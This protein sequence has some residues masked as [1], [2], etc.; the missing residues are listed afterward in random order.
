MRSGTGE[1]AGRDE[2]GSD[3][4]DAE[5]VKGSRG[6]MRWKKGATLGGSSGSDSDD[7]IPRGKP[8]AQESDDSLDAVARKMG[9]TEPEDDSGAKR[10]YMAKVGQF[11]EKDC[12][13]KR[14]RVA[15]EKR[16]CACQSVR[17]P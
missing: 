3:P 6:G 16:R 4:S 5:V 1:E 10:R 11:V 12:K 2:N 8:T 15:F 9:G 13:A 17:P 14:D 7:V